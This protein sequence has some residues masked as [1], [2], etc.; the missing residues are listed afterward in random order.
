M[1]V[2]GSLSWGATT[3]A[4]PSRGEGG[5]VKA[6]YLRGHPQQAVVTKGCQIW[7]GVA[8]ASEP[9]YADVL[10]SGGTYEH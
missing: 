8:R 5:P 2:A 3:V 6:M 10:G 4:V 1:A 9:G 7:P